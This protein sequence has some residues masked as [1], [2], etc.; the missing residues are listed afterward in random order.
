MGR[1]CS[2]L[3]SEVSVI[4][5]F[6]LPAEWR[7]EVQSVAGRNLVRLP[8]GLCLNQ[9]GFVGWRKM[10]ETVPCQGNAFSVSGTLA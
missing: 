10:I 7:I 6:S 9:G 3:S 1:Q 2:I 5:S 8:I 4:S